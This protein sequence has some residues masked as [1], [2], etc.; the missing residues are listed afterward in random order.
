MTMDP[1]ILVNGA[2]GLSAVAIVYY[3]VQHARR[4]KLITD[5]RVAFLVPGAAWFLLVGLFA[6]APQVATLVL[7]ALAGWTAT[8]LYKAASKDAERTPPQQ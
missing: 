2:F 4:V 3:L 8:L 7:L 1:Q 6:F 5:G